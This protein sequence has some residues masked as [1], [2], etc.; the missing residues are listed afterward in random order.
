MYITGITNT[1]MCITGVW[2]AETDYH[3]MSTFLSI[4]RKWDIGILQVGI[5]KQTSSLPIDSQ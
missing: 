3:S 1:I 2:C 4:P 5:S